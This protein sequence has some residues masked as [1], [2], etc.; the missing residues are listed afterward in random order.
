MQPSIYPSGPTVLNH[1][2]DALADHES[3]RQLVGAYIDSAVRNVGS[4]DA[5]FQRFYRK[6]MELI[7]DESARAIDAITQSPIERTFARA[8]VLCFLEADGLG[9]LVHPTADD[10]A[11]QVADYRRTLSDFRHLGHRPNDGVRRLLDNE[12]TSG[13]M[14]LDEWRDFA[15]LLPRYRSSPF[16]GRYFMTLQPRFPHVRIAGTSVR[17][18]LYFWTPKH[19]DINVIVE[20]DG[21]QYHSGRDKFQSD[22][23]RDRALQARGYEVLRFSGSEIHANP[24][25]A[26]HELATDLW[27]RVNAAEVAAGQR[28]AVGQRA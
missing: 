1:L 16:D 10:T 20:C 4:D 22:R 28:A 13:R 19:P 15:M 23:Q 7:A 3:F 12:L 27:Q 21:Y 9:L 24:L 17:A 11:T 25:A 8:L 6:S 5:D 18:D 26:A 2:R 14:P